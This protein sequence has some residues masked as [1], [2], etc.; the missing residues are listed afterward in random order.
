[1]KSPLKILIIALVFLSANSATAQDKAK[2][3]FLKA[4]ELLKTESVEMAM[5]IDV[6]DDKGRL[7]SKELTVL[8]AKF[9]DEEKT[10]VVWQQ[11]E[12]AKGTTV[13]I[14][15]LPGETGTIEVYTPSNDKT[16]KLRAT[17]ANMNLIGSEFNMMSFANSNPEELNYALLNDTVIN[18]ISCHQIKVSGAEAKDQ[19]GAVLVIR[20]DSN[21]IIQVSR[22]DENNKAVSLS[23]LSDYKKIA[24]DGSKM[25][26][27]HI[28]TTDYEGNKRID[29]RI[30]NVTAKKG[31]TKD[32][33]SL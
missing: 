8:M 33:F 21:F 18:S 27:T 7:K 4:T 25:Y 23:H 30:M 26:P 3:I 16:R 11:P 14:S 1:M 5:A 24:G 10:K 9:G 32:A 15:Q 19:S 17:D 31:L 12:R 20:K 28:T 2:D 22:F 13:V 29:I 6:T